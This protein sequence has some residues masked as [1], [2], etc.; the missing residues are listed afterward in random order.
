MQSHINV[1]N[2]TDISIKELAEIIKKIV[3]YKGK[4]NFD[5]TKPDGTPR[6]FLNSEKINKLNFYPKI[7]LKSGLIKTYKDYIKP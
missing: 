7:S 4:I 3:G 1:G 6:K 5:L 2:G